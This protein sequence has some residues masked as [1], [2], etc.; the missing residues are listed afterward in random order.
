MSYRLNLAPPVERSVPTTR[1]VA[2]AVLGALASF[3]LIGVYTGGRTLFEYLDWLTDREGWL[4]DRRQELNSELEKIESDLDT[5]Y[6]EKQRVQEAQAEEDAAAN[7][8][9]YY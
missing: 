6:A 1:F 3:L 7:D 8:N 4:L 5:L 2:E 9:E